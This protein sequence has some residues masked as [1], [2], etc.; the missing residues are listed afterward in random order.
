[1]LRK[2]AALALCCTLSPLPVFS[3]QQ[4]PVVQSA[5]KF[6]INE[7]AATNGAVLLPGDS[8]QTSS[9]AAVVV[10]KGLVLNLGPNS[11]VTYQ[12]P[13]IEFGRGSVVVTTSAPGWQVGVGA[14]SIVATSASAKV[15]V[16]AKENVALIK[17]LEG[18]ATLH[19]GTE[20]TPLQ[21]GFTVARPLASTP[22]V[23]A[24][25]PKSKA[26]YIAAAAG[27]GVAAVVFAAKGSGSSRTPSSPARP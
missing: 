26:P 9:E 19:E 10:A 11:L 22:A 25:K 5:G 24:K 18:A 23:A 2:L 1:M 12:A 8:L 21:I 3:Q 16:V 20:A 17:L 14:A 6:R 13:K 15:E 27:G 4:G 7:R